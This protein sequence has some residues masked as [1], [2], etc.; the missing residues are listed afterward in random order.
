MLKCLGR[1][2]L[3]AVC[4]CAFPHATTAHAIDQQARI[5]RVVD[6][7]KTQLAIAQPVQVSIVE[8]NPKLFSVVPAERQHGT[9]LLS[10]QEDF[11]QG[12]NDAELRAAVAHELGH[13]WI[14]TH[15]PFLQT[16]Q[17]ANDI[18][19]RVVSRDSLAPLYEK[20]WKRVG[21]A[22]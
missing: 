17:L 21:G 15:F 7:L 22:D 16:E 9:F 2:F 18:A 4:V 5:Q 14:F 20:V 12:L 19:S 6:D 8:T 13:V 3:C 1:S 10:A 11:A